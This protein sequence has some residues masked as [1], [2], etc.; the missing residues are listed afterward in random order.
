MAKNEEKNNLIRVYAQ[1]LFN[2]STSFYHCYSLFYFEVT[3]IKE[4]T[5]TNQIVSFGLVDMGDGPGPFE[6]DAYLCLDNSTSSPDS[7]GEN[8]DVYGCGLVI[9]PKNESETQKTFVFFTKN[10]TE[11]GEEILI[12]EDVDILKPFI[13]LL[14]CSVEV[15]FGNDLETMPFLYDISKHF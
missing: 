14:S 1:H 5:D 12:E 4:T 8:G 13:K 6:T 10:G 3:I 7:S 15:N 9:P 2:K 11:I